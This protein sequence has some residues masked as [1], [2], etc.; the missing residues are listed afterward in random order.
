MSRLHIL[1]VLIAGIL[2]VGGCLG[3]AVVGEPRVNSCLLCGRIDLPAECG[4]SAFAK[5][6][7][8]NEYGQ[9]YLLE[10][11][12]R[13]E[14]QLEDFSGEAALIYAEKGG[15]ALA[16]SL[17]PLSSEAVQNFVE[18]NAYT[19]AQVAV[20]EVAKELYPQAVFIRDIPNF[21]VP[22]SLV[23]LVAEEIAHCANPLH[24]ARVREK[25]L[26][27]IDVWFGSAQ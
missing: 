2:F 26:E 17:Y 16:A 11:N 25:A 15:M 5:V 23:S 1:P 21:L 14:F 19:T 3:G 10:A 9:V 12:S 8:E 20:Y 13:G 22:E 27:I 24:S 6:H 7:I 4:G 18:L